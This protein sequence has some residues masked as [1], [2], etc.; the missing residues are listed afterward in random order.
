MDDMKLRNLALYVQQKRM[1]FPL[2]WSENGKCTCG[3]NSCRSAGKHP[4]TQSGLYDATNDTAT[5]KAWHE[6]FPNANWGMRTGNQENGGSGLVVVD[7]D[8]KSNGF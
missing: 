4:Q 6:R 8:I 2:Q 1:I 3:N 5:I 7:I